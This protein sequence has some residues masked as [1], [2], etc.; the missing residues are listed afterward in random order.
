MYVAIYIDMYVFISPLI[1]KVVSEDFKCSVF[2]RQFVTVHIKYLFCPF[3][4]ILN[5]KINQS[6][7]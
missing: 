3:C 1:T 6:T 2:Y 5:N 7:I 4:N